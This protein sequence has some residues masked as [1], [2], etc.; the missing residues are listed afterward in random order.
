[1]RPLLIGGLALLGACTTRGET[2][3]AAGTTGQAG[4]TVRT[5]SLP[6]PAFDLPQSP[7]KDLVVAN[8]AICHSLRYLTHQ[9]TLARKTWASEVDKMAKVYGAPIPAE[10]TAA[11]VEYLVAV[12]GREE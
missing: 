3:L 7:G 2:Q 1:M 10:K 9:P 12:N 5:V 8:C 4:T 6:E 11:I